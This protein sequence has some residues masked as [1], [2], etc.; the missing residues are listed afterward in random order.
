M[1]FYA[2]ETNFMRN[3]GDYLSGDASYEEA[4]NA[5]ERQLNI[6]LSE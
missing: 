1:F 4:A 3:I 2:K 6:Y 5:A